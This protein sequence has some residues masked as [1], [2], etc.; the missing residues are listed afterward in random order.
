MRRDLV[1]G[2]IAAVIVVSLTTIVCALIASHTVTIA[3]QPGIQ[4]LT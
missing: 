3:Q 1:I 2:G 4:S